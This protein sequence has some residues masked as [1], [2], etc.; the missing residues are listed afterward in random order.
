MFLSLRILLTE[1]L[2]LYLTNHDI[3]IIYKF[4]G[5]CIMLTI[6]PYQLINLPPKVINVFLLVTHMVRKVGV[7]LI[8]TPMKILFLMM[9]PSTKISYLSKHPSHNPHRL[10]PRLLQTLLSLMIE[11][12]HLLPNLL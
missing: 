3:T 4:L 10:L 1:L 9:F 12:L 7:F 6:N 11:N 2:L 8:S 5:A